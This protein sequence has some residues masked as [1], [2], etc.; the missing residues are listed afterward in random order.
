MS[1]FERRTNLGHHRIRYQGG[2]LAPLLQ[3][4]IDESGVGYKLFPAGPEG[5]Q[6]FDHAVGQ[7]LLALDATYRRVAAGRDDHVQLLLRHIDAV[8][9]EGHADVR[10]ARI[11]AAYPGRIGH[12]RHDLLSGLLGRI[13][14]IDRVVV[15]FA[16][17]APVETWELGGLGQERF[18]F[19]ED[20]A[21][22]M[23]EAAGYFTGDFQVRQ[24]VLSDRYAG[25]LVE[26]D[27]GRHQHRVAEKAEGGQ[28]LG[29]QVVLHL[30]VGRA[31]LQ[32]GDR[33]DHR[34]DQVQLGMVRHQALAE[35]DAFCRVKP[36]GDPI[37]HHL[38]DA[39]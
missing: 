22:E 13:G 5:S 17:L 7:D 18:G 9:V 11:V 3:Q 6:A 8:Q 4:L 20:L 12:H 19:G 24:L 33:R 16:H 30:L 21:I 14:E 28:I 25:G 35:D 2:P 38:A 36:E 32:P 15:R 23:V 1:E 10:F 29:F 26:N 31:S 37:E 39:L 34:Q 27:V